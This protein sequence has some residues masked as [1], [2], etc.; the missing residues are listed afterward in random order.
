MSPYVYAD[1]RVAVSTADDLTRRSSSVLGRAQ[2]SAAVS[3]ATSG[4]G[5]S[6]NSNRSHQP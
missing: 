6:G 1:P 2:V 4:T 3:H 5:T